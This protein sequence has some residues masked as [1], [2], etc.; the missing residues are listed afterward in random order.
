MTDL[1]YNS[2]ADLHS[3][4]AFGII[5]RIMQTNEEIA[6]VKNSTETLLKIMTNTSAADDQKIIAIERFLQEYRTSVLKY[7]SET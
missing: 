4:S 7:M 2:R 1:N 6:H 3:N 5:N